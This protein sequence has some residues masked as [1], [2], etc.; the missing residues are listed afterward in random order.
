M[1][2]NV[3]IP[4][5]FNYKIYLK[6]NKDFPQNW[7]EKEA[8]SHYLNYG[9]FENRIYSIDIP[10]DFEWNKYILL[11]SDIPQ[12]WTEIEAISHYLNYGYFENR[13]Y[14]ITIPYNFDWQKYI[15]LNLDFPQNWNEKKAID[16]YLKYGYFE[17]RI[18]KNYDFNITKINLIENDNSLISNI[19]YNDIE[20]G[21]NLISLYNKSILNNNFI[22]IIDFPN[23]GGG[24]EFFINSIISKYKKKQTFII[25]RNFNEKIQLNINNKYLINNYNEQD[26]IDF[27]NL[28]K[29]K[30][31][32]IFINHIYKHSKIFLN[33]IIGLNK[34]IITISHDYYLINEKTQPYYNE[35]DVNYFPKINLNKIN[36]LIIQ[37]EEILNIYKD[38]LKEKQDIVICPLPDFKDSLELINTDNKN[39][40]IGIIGCIG[41]IKGFKILLDIINYIKYNNLNIKVIIFGY[42]LIQYEHQYYYNSI[43]EFNNLLKIHK[44]NI[45]F[46][47]SIWPET[48]SYTLTLAMITQLPILSLKKNFNNVIENRLKEYNK[49]Y[50]YNNIENFFEIIQQNIKQDYFYTINPIVY[51]N[52]FWDQIFVL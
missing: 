31:H 29:N 45:L 47:T 3:V 23:M 27:L 30:I 10:I 43:D 36:K 12:N 9:Y 50:F 17:N 41:E 51:Y 11:N 38:F 21:K 5:N 20:N 32:K 48:Y 52:S 1:S 8:I 18:Y 40:V 35:I 49:K 25:A 2:D 7:N 44:P 16:H 22:L 28:L 39:I 26:A 6:L 46:E 42:S 34:E 24:T 15:L 37:N 14:K 33:F 13:R 19:N 4:N